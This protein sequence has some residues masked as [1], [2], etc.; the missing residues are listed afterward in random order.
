MKKYSTQ[1][2]QAIQRRKTSI[3]PSNINSISSTYYKKK[4]ARRATNARYVHC[5]QAPNRDSMQRPTGS[6]SAQHFCQKNGRVPPILAFSAPNS[7]QKT[8]TLCS[9]QITTVFIGK[10]VCSTRWVVTFEAYLQYMW[11]IN[12]KS[13]YSSVS[14][15]KALVPF[16]VL[17]GFWHILPVFFLSVQHRRLAA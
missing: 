4:S 6:L 8:A 3:A 16:L 9:F 14:L 12:K 17:C 1:A 2:R 11:G 5:L 15:S 7:M 13:C 10:I